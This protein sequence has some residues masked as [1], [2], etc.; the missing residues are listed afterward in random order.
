[1]PVGECLENLCVAPNM[2]MI[3]ASPPGKA[4]AVGLCDGAGFCG[5]DAATPCTNSMEC[6][7]AYPCCCAV[8]MGTGAGPSMSTGT[9]R[10]SNQCG[11]LAGGTCLP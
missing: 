1:M 3:T 11:M 10:T 7:G 4:C 5:P 2:C 8:E 6:G 9:C